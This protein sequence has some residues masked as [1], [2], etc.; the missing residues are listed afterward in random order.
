MVIILLTLILQTTL[1][2]LLENLPP[3]VYE[4][5]EVGA[6]SLGSSGISGLNKNLAKFKIFKT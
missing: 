3:T 4:D 5:N 6:S 1:V 2:S